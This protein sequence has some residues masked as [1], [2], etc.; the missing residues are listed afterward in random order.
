MVHTDLRRSSRKR[1]LGNVLYLFRLGLRAFVMCSIFMPS[2]DHFTGRCR[3]RINRIPLHSVEHAAISLWR[4]CRMQYVK[5]STF[6]ISLNY[7][8]S[9]DCLLRVLRHEHMEHSELPI[10]HSGTSTLSRLVC[11]LNFE[12]SSSCTTRT[13][14]C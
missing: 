9:S 5:P 1:R 12:H 11:F 3:W 10:P 2:D 13:A 8:S 14:Q 6:E 4:M 7:S